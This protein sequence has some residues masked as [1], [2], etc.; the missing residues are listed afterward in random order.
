M[1]SLGLGLSYF[2]LKAVGGEALNKYSLLGYTL[3]MAHRPH[4]SPV[5]FINNV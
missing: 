5:G 3:V 4:L 1:P 2:V